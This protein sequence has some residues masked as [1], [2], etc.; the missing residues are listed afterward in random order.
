MSREGK[1]IETRKGTEL[2]LQ[3]P[4]DPLN[5]EG[6]EGVRWGIRGGREETAPKSRNAETSRRK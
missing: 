2:A 1:R 3:L 4:K 5:D 6:V